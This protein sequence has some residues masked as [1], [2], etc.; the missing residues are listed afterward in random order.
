MRSM[1]V[2]VILLLGATGCSSSSAPVS[3]G[4]AGSQGPGDSN[5]DAGACATFGP[6]FVMDSGDHKCKSDGFDTNVGAACSATNA[7]ACGTF[8]TASCL[9]PIADSYPDGYCTIDPCS[10]VEGHLC[11]IGASCASPNGETP[12]CFKNCKTDADC[13]G[14]HYACVNIDPLFTSGTSHTVCV[15]KTFICP[16][17]ASDCPAVFPHCRDADAGAPDGGGTAPVGDGG[18]AFTP[19]TEPVCF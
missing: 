13:R 6:H 17:S 5:A 8:P 18:P 3:P 15:R 7:G 12:A 4:G 1:S 11:P 16:N 9:D 19:I 14:P 2:G 10:E